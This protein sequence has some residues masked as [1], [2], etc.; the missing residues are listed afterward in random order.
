MRVQYDPNTAQPTGSRL[1]SPTIDISMERSSS[2]PL[3]SHRHDFRLFKQQRHLLPS[4]LCEGL[5]SSMAIPGNMMHAPDNRSSA[6]DTLQQ[7]TE[8]ISNFKYRA[9]FRRLPLGV[10]VIEVGRQSYCSHSEKCVVESSQGRGGRSNSS[11]LE[12]ICGFRLV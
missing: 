7:T 11:N 1:L 6:P 3:M 8:E 9:L 10:C 4:S 5:M 2:L 12:S